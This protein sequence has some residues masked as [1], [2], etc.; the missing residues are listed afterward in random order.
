M[1]YAL[2]VWLLLLPAAVFGQGSVPAGTLLPVRLDTDLNGAHARADEAIRA[3]IMQDVPGTPIRRGAKLLGRVESASPARIELR[4]DTI[5]TG[6]SKLSVKTNLRAL[7]SLLAVEEAQIPEGGADRTLTPDQRNSQQIGG[8]TVYRQGGPVTLGED[9][10]GQPAPYGILGRVQSN[11]RCRGEM[12][13]T[14][15]QAFWLFSTNACG[16]YGYD[17]DVTIAHAGR[18][19][20][21]GT[22]VLVAKSGKLKIRSGSGLLLR[23]Q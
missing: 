15:P 11:G 5:R 8:E 13:T 19:R 4:F 20:P 2:L 6:G 7:A 22:I 14:A 18:T 12:G 17:E 21:V 1:R 9:V 23:V 10:V 3:T 16:V